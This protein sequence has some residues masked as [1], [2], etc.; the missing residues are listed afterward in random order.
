MKDIPERYALESVEQLRVI[1]DELRQR[2]CDALAA[3]P[4]TVTQLGALLDVPPA[5]I[6]YHVR[7]LVRVGLVRQVETREKGG[8]LEKYYRVVA[9]GFVVPPTL[10]SAMPAGDRVATG[11]TLVAEISRGLVE[12]VSRRVVAESGSS[13]KLTLSRSYRWMTDEEAADVYAQI[14]RLLEPY[15]LRNA[16]AGAEE[17]AVVIALYSL[18]KGNVEDG[19]PPPKQALA[20][21]DTVY[22][23]DALETVIRSGETLDLTAVGDVTFADD[24]AP[25][26]VDAAISRLR[27]HG[28]L[29]ASGA[30]RDVLQTKGEAP[31][32]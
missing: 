13:A 12:A 18:N 14:E 26:A 3:R 28:T 10:L 2:I 30:V 20:V 22:D 32:S 7:E 23:R 17:R 31:D 15:E 21:G 16:D 8:V 1:A 11:E 19:S 25:E 24:V 29:H 9:E 6:L 27:L 4:M 5:R